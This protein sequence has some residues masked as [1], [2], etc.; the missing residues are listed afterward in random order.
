MLFKNAPKC[1]GMIVKLPEYIAMMIL[2]YQCV[3]M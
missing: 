1:S 2:Q 3:V